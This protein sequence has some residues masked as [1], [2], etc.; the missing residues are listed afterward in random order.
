MY[1]SKVKTH[2]LTI[3]AI[4]ENN[5][6]DLISE[7]SLSDEKKNFILNVWKKY[8]V[9]LSRGVIH[10]QTLQVNP[11]IDMDW[12]FGVSIGSSEL[13]QVGN[14]FLQLKFITANEESKHIELDLNQFYQFLHE[15]EKAKVLLDTFNQ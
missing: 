14:T 2:K 10:Q 5:I 4:K 6:Q 7:T 9:Q 11:L 3:D 15:M 1:Y 12:R 8:Y 13:N